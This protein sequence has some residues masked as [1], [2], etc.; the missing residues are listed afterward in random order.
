MDFTEYSR[1]KERKN[2]KYTTN[3]VD[4]E[5]G[6]YVTGLVWAGMIEPDQIKLIDAETLDW[7]EGQ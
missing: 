7:L 5:S 1:R 6:I 3:Y 4:V 2:R